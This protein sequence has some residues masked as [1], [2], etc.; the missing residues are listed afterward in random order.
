MTGHFHIGE[1]SSEC[2][3][4]LFPVEVIRIKLLE[5]GVVEGLEIA[6]ATGRSVSGAGTDL[7]KMFQSGVTCRQAGNEP[8]H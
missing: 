3:K 7:C 8:R 5:R 6:T 2:R 4:H 1:Q